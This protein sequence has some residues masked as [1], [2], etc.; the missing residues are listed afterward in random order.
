MGFTRR[1]FL[2]GSV[3]V[4]GAVGRGCAV[5]ENQD[6]LF[7]DHPVVPAGATVSVVRPSSFSTHAA[8][9]REAVRLAGGLS[10]IRPGER[11]LLKPAVN[12]GNAYP[13]TVDP[14]TLLVM[15]LLV[16]EA[17]GEP[18]VADRSF[19]LSNTMDNFEKVGI[20]DAAAQ[21]DIPLLAL[22]SKGLT[23]LHHPLAT[24][25]WG[26]TIPIYRDVATAHHIINLC[27]PRT[28]FQ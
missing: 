20:R 10:F 16:K 12:S 21:L 26:N 3:L 11:V 23:L 27:T 13:A 8:A 28:H 9:V 18:Y 15:G 25:W 24:H 1:H 22:E 17:G 19:F 5:E 7:A 6:H 2:Q 4:A 14:E